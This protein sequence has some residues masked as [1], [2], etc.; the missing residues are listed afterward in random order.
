MSG[1]LTLLP[2]LPE[3]PPKG[4]GICYLM[5]DGLKLKF[6]FTTRSIRQRRGE[7]RATIVGYMTGTRADERDLHAMV[8][9]WALGGEWFT[10]PDNPSVYHELRCLVDKLTGVGG[11][12]PRQ[13]FDTIVAHHL[14]RAG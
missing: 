14:R 10:V 1:Q 11:A 6:G 9:K 12:D 4:G 2:E 3:E 8:K 5:T 13:I 7:L